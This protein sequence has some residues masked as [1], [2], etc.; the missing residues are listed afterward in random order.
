M[1]I[2]WV[3]DILNE[4]PG[5]AG[6]LIEDSVSTSSLPTLPVCLC[7]GAGCVKGFMLALP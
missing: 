5:K 3:Q 2:A 4:W 1:R 7:V 6:V